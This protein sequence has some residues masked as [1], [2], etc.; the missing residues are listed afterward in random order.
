MLVSSLLSY[1]ARQ[2]SRYGDGVVTG[3]TCQRIFRWKIDQ[4]MLT[5]KSL[6][7]PA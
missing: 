4:P 6:R 1:L 3:L 7:Y 2:G 5:L